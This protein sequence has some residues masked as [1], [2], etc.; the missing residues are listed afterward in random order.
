MI[1]L[2]ANLLVSYEVALILLSMPLSYCWML[3]AI[4]SAFRP[5]TPNEETKKLG[6]KPRRSA[7]L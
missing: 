4:Q 3:A 6:L 1:E 5:N 2:V 7:P